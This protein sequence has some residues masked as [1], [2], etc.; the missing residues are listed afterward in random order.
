MN[1]TGVKVM[2]A[3]LAVLLVKMTRDS[4]RMRRKKWG[5]RVGLSFGANVGLAGT[6]TVG[7]ASQRS[8]AC[9]PLTRAVRAKMGRR[10]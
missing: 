10:M 5:G 2:T 6:L 3:M 9:Q 4:T 8:S 7:G 1:S